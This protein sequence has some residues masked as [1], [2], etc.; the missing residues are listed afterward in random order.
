MRIGIMGDTHGDI[1][2]I[3]QAVA[4]AGPVEL[5]LHTGDFC[6]DAQTLAAIT[7]VPVTSVA[8]NCDGR[9]DAN[10]DEFIE[11][12]GYRIWLTHGHRHGVKQNLND[13]CN[14][15][16]QYEADIVVYGHTHQADVIQ[17]PELLLFNPGSAAMPRRGKNRTCG[18][19]ELVPERNGMLS[20][21]IR[22]C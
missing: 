5:W 10:P 8:G 2:S 13:L 21:L 6:R 19:L 11:A 17:E 20:H 14:W 15:A 16:H 4:A 12:A 1:H 18:V 22:V 7:G 3:K 9:A